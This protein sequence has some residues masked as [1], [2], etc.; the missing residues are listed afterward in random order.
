MPL[1]LRVR[2]L[3]GRPAVR[4]LPE[5]LRPQGEP[6]HCGGEAGAFG[7]GDLTLTRLKVG[8]KRNQ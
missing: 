7:V 8:D 1:R 3:G 6:G 2:E 4:P 5:G